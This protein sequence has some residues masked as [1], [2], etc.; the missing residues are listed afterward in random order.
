MF[1]IDIRISRDEDYEWTLEQVDNFLLY[2][3]GMDTLSCTT[4]NAAEFCKDLLLE[5]FPQVLVFIREQQPA[6]AR[7]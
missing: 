6:R 4:Y 1:T 7:G 5:N 3:L 2:E